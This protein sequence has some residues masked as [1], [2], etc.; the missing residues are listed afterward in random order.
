M[1]LSYVHFLEILLHTCDYTVEV[2][3]PVHVPVRVGTRAS[4]LY[5][6]ED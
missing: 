4:D 6:T 2:A 1:A 3:I 5:H